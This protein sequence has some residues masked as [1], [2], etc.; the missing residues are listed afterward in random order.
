MVD[1]VLSEEIQAV[2]V[3][4]CRRLDVEPSEVELLRRHSNT[5]FK[6]P[7]RRLLVRVA[8]STTAHERVAGSIRVTQWLA[9]RGYPT[10]RPAP[11]PGQPWL[12][13]QHTVSVWQLE[14]VA[15]GVAATGA[16]L[17]RLLAELHQQPVPPFEV[18]RLD[19]P[20]ASVAAALDRAPDAVPGEDV[21]WLQH[22]VAELREVWRGLDYARPAC[23]VHGDAHPNNVLRLNDGRLLLSDWDHV[24]I[25]P[26]EWDLVQPLYTRRRFGRPDES[27]VEAFAAGY[28]WD[29]RGWDGVEQLLAVREVTG[30]SPYI[31]NAGEDEWSLSELVRRVRGLRAGDTDMCWGSPSER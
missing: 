16:E 13:R 5:S 12:I 25:G 18:R 4:V 6:V 1:N 31:R 9:S 7:G 30:L 11:V 15:D 23:L 20:L 14:D 10:V 22:R 19:D 28:G 26:P 17:G 29:V 8:G 3:E 21:A 2:L 24:A 27:D